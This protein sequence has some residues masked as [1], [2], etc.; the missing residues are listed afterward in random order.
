MWFIENEKR[1][2]KSEGIKDAAANESSAEEQ[3]SAPLQSSL[4]N[5]LDR[6]IEHHSYRF[7]K[8][9]AYPY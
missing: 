8:S 9:N 4:D 2:R 7:S 1:A 3:T 5:L 6:R